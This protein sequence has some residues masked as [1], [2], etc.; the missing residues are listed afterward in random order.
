M[1]STCHE[2]SSSYTTLWDPITVGTMHLP[3]RLA[4]APMTRDRARPD[5]V[6]NDLNAEYYRQRASTAFIATEGIQPS[7]DG[8]GY[9]LIPGLHA[10]PQ[11]AGWRDA[12]DAVHAEGG[13]IIAQLMHT[14]RA[15]HP[16]NTPAPPPV[17]GSTPGWPTWTPASPTSSRSVR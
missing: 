3:H 2:K 15:A 5:G 1:L 9:L 4:M 13:R 17:G 7:E 6:P 11:V 12:T 14:G 8:Q 10:E 16:D